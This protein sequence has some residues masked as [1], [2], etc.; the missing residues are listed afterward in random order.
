MILN[1]LSPLCCF[2]CRPQLLYVENLLKQDADLLRKHS[3]E[4]KLAYS[5]Y[6]LSVCTTLG[7]FG[8]I[9][10]SECREIKKLITQDKFNE[11]LFAALFADID[12]MCGALED[13]FSSVSLNLRLFGEN[14]KTDSSYFATVETILK[15]QIAGDEGKL[16]LLQN[17]ESAYVTA[18][19][20]NLEEASHQTTK[21]LIEYL[22]WGAVV[23]ISLAAG[24]IEFA[25]PAIETGETILMNVVK[26]GANAAIKKASEAG[27]ETAKEGVKKIIE[28]V[29]QDTNIADAIQKRGEKLQEICLL[30]SDVAVLQTL[31]ASVKVLNFKAQVVLDMVQTI[32][33]D[34]SKQRS[35]M[36]IIK[37]AARSDQEKAKEMLDGA[38]TLWTSVTSA[39]QTL[40]DSFIQSTEVIYP[41]SESPRA[42]L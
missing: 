36:T 41:D 11:S 23:G 32:R 20:Q 33:D 24:Q 19:N 8:S 42:R 9:V 30:S 5:G 7:S 25:V 2:I 14:L 17:E 13:K 12:E 29:S 6:P 37:F 34:I 16:R 28:E 35:N 4:W 38:I 31:I 18:I 3:L 10:A 26:T 15:S 39:A 1:R 27:V 22:E 40:Q 21:F